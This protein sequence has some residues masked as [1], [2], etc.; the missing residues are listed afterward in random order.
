[1]ASK[2]KANHPK[3][4]WIGQSKVD[5]E[6]LVGLVRDGLISNV[7]KV[8]LLGSH[9][10]PEPKDDEAIVFMDYFRAGLRFLVMR[11]W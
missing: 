9:E 8:R 11:W 4:Y 6:V 2:G 7:L 3:T 10:T 5:D 1:M